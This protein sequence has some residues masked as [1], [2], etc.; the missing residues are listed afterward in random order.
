MNKVLKKILIE[1]NVDGAL[2]FVRE[3]INDI[4]HN[5]VDISKL[6]ISKTL[7]PNYTN[8]QPHAVLALSLIHI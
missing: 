1:R 4:L 5:K 2:A 3:T 8:P 7:A 6:I